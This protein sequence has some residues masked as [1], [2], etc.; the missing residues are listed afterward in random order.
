MSSIISDKFAFI[1][2]HIPRTGGTSWTDFIRRHDPDM[3]EYPHF[4][5]SELPDKYFKFSIIRNPFERAISLFARTATMW[6][7]DF[8]RFLK[9]PFDWRCR[10][11]FC[12]AEVYLCKDGKELF[13]KVFRFEDNPGRQLCN[14]F[15]V[16]QIDYPHWSK[17]NHGP[18]EDYFSEEAKMIVLKR[19]AWELKWLYP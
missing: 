19:C 1:F 14:K 6:G 18:Y 4:P 11:T 3:K 12:P 8:L 9:E 5:L 17:T 13:D 2:T 16:E 15:G 10:E 7:N